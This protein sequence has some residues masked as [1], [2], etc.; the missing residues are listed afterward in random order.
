MM[1]IISNASNSNQKNESYKFGN[2]IHRTTTK[3]ESLVAHEK[4]NGNDV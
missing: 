4:Q 2:E 1:E 3:G